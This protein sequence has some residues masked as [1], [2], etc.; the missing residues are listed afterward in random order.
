MGGNNI[1]NTSMTALV[2]CFARAYH[3]NNYKYKILDD[4]LATKLLTKE[5][6]D[7]ISSNMANGINFFN[8]EFIGTN[9]E[10]L[11]YI[12]DNQL[13]QSVIARSV[14]TEE[15]LKNEIMLGAKQYLIFAS[16]YDTSSYRLN[17]NLDIFEI[18]KSEMI[19]DKIERL[20]KAGIKHD[21]VNYI[22]CDLTNENFIDSIINSNY[23]LNKKTFCSL[24]GISYYLSKS[25]FD[26][27]INKISKILCEGSSIVF[28][29]PTMDETE[30]EKIN[31]ELASKANEEMKSN[32]SYET[33]EK[34][35]EANNCLIYEH[36][37]YEDIN[38]NYFNKYNLL[39]PNNKTLAPK[40]VN[41]CLM[42][43]NKL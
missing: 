36:L 2:S 15:K 18:D 27:M 24:L 7:N 3:S 11:R 19:K 28:D 5:E 22:E 38:N 12:V 26:K 8:K 30:K 10:A 14:F 9:E 1:N 13:S 43:K 16:G 4:Y 42:I 33:I 23:D 6:Y 31:K 32:Y 29:Y 20:N 39:N 40:G 25:D 35:A 37:N 34:I 17:N 21:N 41:Y